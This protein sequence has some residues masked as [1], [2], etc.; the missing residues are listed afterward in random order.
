MAKRGAG[1]Q[2]RGS[3]ILPGGASGDIPSTPRDHCYVSEMFGALPRPASG[4][5]GPADRAP[6]AVGLR[7][8]ARARSGAAIEK[9]TKIRRGE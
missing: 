1:E 8:P 7:R 9:V 2:D 5:S 4:R 6:G 3:N